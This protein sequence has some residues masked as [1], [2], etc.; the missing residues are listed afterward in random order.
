MTHRNLTKRQR[1]YKEYRRLCA[2][3]RR[4]ERTNDDRCALT[5]REDRRYFNLLAVYG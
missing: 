3:I 2:K 1:M 4:W 5:E